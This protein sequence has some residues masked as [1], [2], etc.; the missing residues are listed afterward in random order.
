VVDVRHHV[1]PQ[2][3]LQLCDPAEV[4]CVAG[5]FH[6]RERGF[7]DLD[8]ELPLRLGKRD[9]QVSPDESRVGRREDVG[10]LFR[11]VTVDQWV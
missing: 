11:R 10:H 5:L 4:E 6:L 2:L 7:G 9:P 3:R 1:V 8:P